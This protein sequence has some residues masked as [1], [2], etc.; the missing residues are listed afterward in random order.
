MRKHFYSLILEFFQSWIGLND[1]QT[2]GTFVWTNGSSVDFISWESAPVQQPDNN[3]G[4]EDCVF[5]S[6]YTLNDQWKDGDCNEKY[7]YTCMK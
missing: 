4:N 1:H 3:G 6:G 5:V 2:E 7:G